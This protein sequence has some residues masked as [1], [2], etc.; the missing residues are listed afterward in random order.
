MVRPHA[1]ATGSDARYADGG[2]QLLEGGEVADLSAAEHERQRSAASVAREVDVLPAFTEFSR[3]IRAEPVRGARPDRPW[4]WRAGYA[5]RGA[6]AKE[7]LKRLHQMV[8]LRI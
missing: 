1:W 2:H 6:A 5:C 8:T 7:T 4:A 3:R